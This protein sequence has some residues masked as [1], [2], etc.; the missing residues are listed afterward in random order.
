MPHKA[1]EERQLA[2]LELIHSDICEMNGVLIEGGQIYFMTMTDDASIYCY[3]YLL[4]IK[5]EALNYF[6]TYEAKVKNQLEKKIKHF[7]PDHGDEYFSSELDSFCV[8]DGIIHESTPS[9]SPQSNEVAERKN[10]TLT[11]LVNSMLNTAGLF[12]A[13]WGRLY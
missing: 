12:K 1:T 5:D 9:Y 10:R 8:E 13:W 2:P 11:N 3:T 6:K 7:M 4:K